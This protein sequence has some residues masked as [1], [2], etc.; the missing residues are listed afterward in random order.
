MAPAAKHA[1]LSPS[2]AHRWL[3]CPPSARLTE[4]M[5]DKPSSYAEEGTRAHALCEETLTRS[6]QAWSDGE[7]EGYPAASTACD[8]PDREP[9]EMIAAAQTYVDFIHE[10]WMGS[11]AEPAVYIEQ[12]VCMDTWVPECSGTC[13][14]LLITNDCLHIIDFKYGKG[15]AVSAEENPQLKLYALGA[16]QLF[17]GIYEISTVRMSIVQPRIKAEPDTWEISADD[18]LR[19]AKEVLTPAAK[20][21]WEGEGDLNPGQSQ[22]RFCKAYPTCRAWANKY[23]PL[24][25]F[26]PAP[27]QLTPAEL[28]EWLTKV[29]DLAAY[30]KDLQEYALQQTLDGKP[31]PGWKA[32][33]GVSKRTWADEAAAF[34]AMQARLNIPV[35]VLYKPRE[36]ITLTEAEKLLGKKSFAKTCGQYITRKPGAPKLVPAS[37][38][39]PAITKADGFKDLDA[40]NAQG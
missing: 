37:D 17:A 10:L 15:V 19:W 29:Q 5:P 16:L 6:L 23:G 40:P 18:L 4:H 33:E 39:R 30:A 22:C 32:V 36:H 12:P 2:S 38:K 14:C 35:D 1:L 24:A 25:G 31:V 13:D 28:G 7:P 27:A 34:D 3:A 20:L 8:G 26:T 11:V 21:A 9:E